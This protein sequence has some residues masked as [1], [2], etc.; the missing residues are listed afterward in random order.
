MHRIN[1][2][3]VSQQESN[4][5]KSRPFAPER[6]SRNEVAQRE[7]GGA[8]TAAHRVVVAVDEVHDVRDEARARVRGR[9][10]HH[11]KVEVRKVATRRREQ[12][13]CTA[14]VVYK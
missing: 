1:A 10:R 2:F 7:S 4:N 9:L 6:S 5:M 3:T 14:L 8:R 11:A 13:A 12:V